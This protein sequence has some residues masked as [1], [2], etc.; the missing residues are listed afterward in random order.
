VPSASPAYAAGLD[1][2]DV[3]VSV[4]GSKVSS[5]AD[6]TRALASRQPGDA[7]PV[8]FERRGD[9]VS[10]QLRLVED[11]R[12]QAVPVEDAGGRVT[13]AQRRFRDAWLASRAP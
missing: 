13:E 5:A 1:R 7:V 2:D 8:D 12:V 3:I 9:P 10:A 6:W 4:A 11:P